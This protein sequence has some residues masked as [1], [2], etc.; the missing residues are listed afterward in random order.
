VKRK[1]EKLITVL[2]TG[3]H[4]LIALAKSMLDDAGIGYYAKN[5]QTE[6]L[7]GLGVFGTG[8]NIAIGPV[9]LQVLEEDSEEAKK[10]LEDLP[11]E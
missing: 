1:E 3:N 4:G 5:E 11:E 2:T 8:Y 6:D 7:I 10:L 9:E